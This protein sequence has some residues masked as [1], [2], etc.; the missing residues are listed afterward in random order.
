LRLKQ[1]EGML[2][3]PRAYSGRSPENARRAL[4]DV[5][6]YENSA[7][8]RRGLVAALRDETAMARLAAAGKELK[9]AVAAR[10]DLAQT[11]GEPWSAAAEATRKLDPR[12]AETRLTLFRGSELL[13]IAG[14]V[15]LYVAET[16]KPNA[17]RLPD[18]RDSALGSL[19]NELFSTAPVYK[20]LEEAML[21]ERFRQVQD[22]LGG[23]HALTGAVR[24]GK[25]PA[26]AAHEAVAG[27]RL[28]S[29]EARRALVKGGP[30]AVAKSNDP[31][32][33][34]A[35]RLEPFYRATVRFLE[36]EIEPV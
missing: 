4:D 1:V 20:D 18:Y 27:T 7:K 10:P 2:E 3:A 26:E 31:M 34:L 23:R 35:R 33:A 16:K 17:E 32:I 30:A 14:K 28:D 6:T 22:V 12:Y 24:G 13:A 21:T 8:A 15:V 5:R 36:E 25:P 11:G 9:D 19:E 29:A